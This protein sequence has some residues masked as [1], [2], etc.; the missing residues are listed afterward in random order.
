MRRILGVCLALIGIG[1][2]SW[3]AFYHI[4]FDAD[5]LNLLPQHL[6]QVGAMRAYDEAFASQ[7]DVLIAITQ[8]DVAIGEEAAE[9]LRSYLAARTDLFGSLSGQP[10][11]EENPSQMGELL[12]Y[13]WANGPT[14]AVSELVSRLS[15][16]G[17]ARELAASLDILENSMDLG[18]VTRVSH[19]P[20]NLTAFGGAAEGFKL[21]ETTRL[22]FVSDDGELHL[23]LAE[24]AAAEGLKDGSEVV[25]WQ[26]EVWAAMAQW[27]AEH[28]D[29]SEGTDVQLTGRKIYMT[30]VTNALR[31][32]LMISVLITLGFV[33]VVFGLI[34]RRLMPLV[35]LLASLYVTFIVTLLLGELIFGALSAMSVG[36]A[37]ILM[38]LAVDYGLVIYQE[39]C[40]SGKDPR[41][42][43]SVFGTSIGWAALTT[44][45]VFLALNRSIMPGAAQLGTMVA[46]GVGVGALMM[47][48]PYASGL[49]YLKCYGL[50]GGQ[51]DSRAARGDGKPWY[52]S[53]RFAGW[54]TVVMVVVLVIVFGS[55]GFP[56]LNSDPEKLRPER[57][58]PAHWR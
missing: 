16:D 55:M 33:V 10:P 9:S 53:G 37:A 2:L 14:E 41:K 6:P 25:A 40:S 48:F 1:V 21:D 45:C 57:R 52:A 11:W 54:F 15:D 58:Q 46:I 28:P 24:P 5:P 22:R 43:R 39:S 44:A 56:Q 34:Y 8:P 51:R 17:V 13:L 38:G 47:I 30:E 23:L 12:A 31:R 27:R 35:V 18:E 26:R 50:R 42:L 19:D 20:L 36:F 3:Q 7:N 4:D 32:D 49:G 29:L